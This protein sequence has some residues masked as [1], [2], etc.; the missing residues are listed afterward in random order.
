[1]PR[2]KRPIAPAV[3]KCAGALLL[4]LP[5]APQARDGWPGTTM[6]AVR[7]ASPWQ[8]PMLPLK[9][10]GADVLLV[11]YVPIV[12]TSY[13]PAA[14]PLRPTLARPGAWYAAVFLPLTP[15]WPLQ[16]RLWQTAATHE[17]RVRLLDG[18]PWGP[19][20]AV[21]PIRM[22]VGR[23]GA[24]REHRSDFFALP[25]ASQAAGVFVLIEQFAAGGARPAPLWL[26]ATSGAAFEADPTRGQA[27]A[28]SQHDQ[29]SLTHT[30]PSP[31]QSPRGT[32]G[33]VELPMLHDLRSGRP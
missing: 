25:A 5:L 30:P 10:D 15:G 18:A 6:P 4:V 33:V 19:V 22:E 27:H 3:A 17:L 13:L 26:Q 8:Q 31:L 28:P 12:L 16:L 29:P 2:S 1:M 11:D 23:R 9:V 32:S 7:I 20:A 24:L 14:G 21:V